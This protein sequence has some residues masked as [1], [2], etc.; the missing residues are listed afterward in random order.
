MT[1]IALLFYFLS[2]LQA[3][4]PDFIGSDLQ[5][6]GAASDLRRDITGVDGPAWVG[7]A[8]PAAAGAHKACNGVFDLDRGGGHASGDDDVGANVELY[9]FSRIVGGEITEVRS[10]AS[11]CRIRAGVSPVFWLSSVSSEDSLRFLDG[12]A[13]R[14]PAADIAESAVHAIAWHAGSAADERLEAFARGEW[15]LELREKAV[16]WMG[17]ARGD[18][19]YRTLAALID[20]VSEREL[21]EKIVF[22]LHLSDADDATPTLIRVARE[23]GDSEVREKALFWLAQEA[24]TQ[25]VAAI[26]DAVRDDPEIDVKKKAVFALSQLPPE[27]GVPLLVE[28]AESHPQPEIRKKAFFW[29]GQSG[30]PQALALIEKVLLNER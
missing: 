21:R 13:R 29:L 2:V 12:V 5:H 18:E 7:Y 16:F 15:P 11:G 14:Q 6:L 30:D 4:Q 25:A 8:V 24:G 26:A 9:V 28:V 1:T 17:A 19:G 23:H 20:E 10:V 27:E 3:T 22:A